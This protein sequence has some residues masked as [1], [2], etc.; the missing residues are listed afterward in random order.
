VARGAYYPPLPN[1]WEG[2][3]DA[4]LFKQAMKPETTKR[5]KARKPIFVGQAPAASANAAG[6]SAAEAAAKLVPAPRMPNEEDLLEADEPDRP[7]PG[8]GP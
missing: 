6:S 3:D 8:A 7:N 5:R 1:R 2:Q 4:A